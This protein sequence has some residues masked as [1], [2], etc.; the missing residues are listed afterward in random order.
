VNATR[1]LVTVIDD[2]ESVR[3]S[4]PDL[5]T[6]LGF[7]TITFAS[8]EAFLSS[9]CIERARC[10]ILDIAMPGMSGLELQQELALRGQNIPIVFITANGDE[11]IRARVLARGAVDCLFKP[12]SEAVLLAAL[13]AAFH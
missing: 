11:S 12:F 4:L 13:K 2:D 1:P 8:A 7:S 10:L 9:D 5:L 6:E 3:E